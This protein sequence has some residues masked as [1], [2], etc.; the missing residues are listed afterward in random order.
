MATIGAVNAGLLTQKLNLSALGIFSWVLAL[1][2]RFCA[3]TAYQLGVQRRNRVDRVV[4]DE[5]CEKICDLEGIAEGSMVRLRMDIAKDTHSSV[6]V[7]LFNRNFLW[8][9]WC[10]TAVLATGLAGLPFVVKGS[11][12]TTT[13]PAP[14]KNVACVMETPSARSQAQTRTHMVTTLL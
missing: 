9:F 7:P 2:V 4:M 6:P 12:T 5:I 13:D 14:V 3:V 10:Q 11:F 1:A 8:A